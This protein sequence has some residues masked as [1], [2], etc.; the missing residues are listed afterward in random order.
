MHC[1]TASKI[2]IEKTAGTTRDL[3]VNK[4]ANRITKVL[5]T[6]SKNNSWKENIWHDRKIHRQ[7]YIYISPEKGQLII[8]D[9]R[10]IC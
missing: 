2:E 4:I 3:I 5:K 1:K 9:V 8:S 6:L 10:A 7:R